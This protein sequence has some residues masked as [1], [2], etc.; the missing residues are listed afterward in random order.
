MFNAAETIDA[1]YKEQAS[2][3]LAVL[4][5]IFGSR[6]FDLAEDVLQEAFRKA[7]V[8][9]NE[10]GIPENPAAWLMTAARNQAID[11]IR[12]Q[13]NQKKFADDLAKHL[14]SDWTLPYAVAQEFDET[15]I[16]DDQLRMIFMCTSAD[17][18][19][20]NRI[21]LILRSLCGLSVPAI[22]RALFLS[23]ATVKKRLLRTR[24]RLVGH[25][26]VFPPVD[27]LPQSMDS[28]HTVLYLLFNEGFH[29]SDGLAAMDLSLC[30]EAIHLVNVLAAEPRVANAD[31]LGLLALM[32]F[33][34]A[35]AATR[36]DAQ[37]FNVPIDLQDRSRWDRERIGIGFDLVRLFPTLPVGASGRYVL[38]AM[39]A[40]L[41]CQ[42]A[43]FAQTD[44]PAIVVLYDQLVKLT[45]SPIAGLNRAVAIAYAGDV[46]QAIEN[47]LALRQH[48]VVKGS[49]LP[50]AILAHLH[51]KLGD[52][53]QAR[54]YAEESTRLGGTPHEQRIMLAQVERLLSDQS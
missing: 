9:W 18:T 52:E 8:T 31:T 32:H 10:Q 5:R 48:E 49:H 20:E 24:E 35:R 6:N 7:L 23:E 33:H 44:W 17:I 54:R 41:H 34:L 39:I 36:V 25:A 11:V 3:L 46:P 15:K 40:A 53:Q 28:V 4:V 51:A 19:P 1:L 38:E 37:G 50:S 2:R 47:V 21:P 43:A 30:L 12:T 27:V 16:K 14:E 45:G 26:F 29:R 13:R 42:A 22:A